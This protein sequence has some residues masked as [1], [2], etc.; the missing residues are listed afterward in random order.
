MK[1][2]L[3]RDVKRFLETNEL[4]LP[5]HNLKSLEA[6]WKKDENSEKGQ[7][8]VGCVWELKGLSSE[9]KML[10]IGRVLRVEVRY[11]L[12]K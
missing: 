12:I 3:I 8:R 5:L 2:S 11:A 4:W 10:G 7:K 9:G 6:N 1:E